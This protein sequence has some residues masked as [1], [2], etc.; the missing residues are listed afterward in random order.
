[1]SEPTDPLMQ[2]L[3]DAQAAGAGTPLGQPQAPDTIPPSFAPMDFAAAQNQG[4]GG[5]GGSDS[6]Y[7]K[8]VEDCDGNSFSVWAK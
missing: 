6:G 8:L 1:M 7:W 2:Q 3:L 5:G 4:S